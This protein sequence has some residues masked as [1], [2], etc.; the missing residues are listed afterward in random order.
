MKSEVLALIPARG[1]S[2]GI[3]RKNLI[4]LLGK[5]LIAWSIEQAISSSYIDRVIVSTDDEEIKEVALNYGAEV[6]FLRPKEISADSSTDFECFHHCLNF[7]EENENYSP[8]IIVHLRPTGPARSVKIVDEAIKLFKENKDFHSLRSVSMA[9]QSPFKMW[10][11]RAGS[12]EHVVSGIGEKA[13]CPRQ[14]LEKAYWQNGYVDIVRGETITK[15]K[16]MTGDNILPYIIEGE[17]RDIDYQEDI[18]I[19]EK[20]LKNILSCKISKN[21]KDKYPV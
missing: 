7:L 10:F 4:N 15:K 1:G 19:V 11:I 16:S 9:Y 2:K 5:P 18:A 20:D 6:P 17:V 14:D 21:S 8:E 13:S 12:L 3:P